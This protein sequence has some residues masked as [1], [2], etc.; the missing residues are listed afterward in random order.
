MKTRNN[1]KYED[2]KRKFIFIDIMK[3]WR[4][5]QQKQLGFCAT[6]LVLSMER[7]KQNW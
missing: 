5:S 6:N 4:S 1:L 7:S 2:M 3:R